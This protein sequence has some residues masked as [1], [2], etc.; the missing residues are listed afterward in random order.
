MTETPSSPAP[1]RVVVVDA[2][3]I[4][5]GVARMACES[6]PRL[7]LVGEA[8]DA[9]QAV[10]LCPR[11]APDVVVIDVDIAGGGIDA[12]RRMRRAGYRGRVL[13]LTEETAGAM[14]L[15]SLRAGVD[16]YLEKAKAL[17]S[18]GSSILRVALGERLI[19]PE[20]ERAAVMELGRFVKTAR[21][22]SRV[23]SSL[24]ARELEVLR[25][26][27]EGLTM[28]TIAKR[29][30]ISPRTVETHATNLYRKLLAGSRLQAVARAASLGLIDLRRA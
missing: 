22:G 10:D 7:E 14:V 1:V 4:F 27:S 21:E 18:L 19:D 16:G 8:E 24:T 28:A 3:P 9:D 26:M 5:R 2:H 25:F 12:I 13:V 30:G 17:R 23:A 6:G 20:L 29:L 11:L 15:D